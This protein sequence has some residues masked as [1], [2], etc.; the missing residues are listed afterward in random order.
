MCTNPPAHVLGRFLSPKRNE[1]I[2]L[3]TS[4][5]GLNFYHWVA[6]CFFEG[7][8]RAR[9]GAPPGLQ[10]VLGLGREKGNFLPLGGGG[11]GLPP[12]RAQT[13]YT[14]SALSKSITEAT[15]CFW[16]SFR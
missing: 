15:P 1:G 6:V 11:R 2:P 16:P 8:R 14:P 12:R 9:G 13:V 3:V 4:L 5:G 10:V 7:Q